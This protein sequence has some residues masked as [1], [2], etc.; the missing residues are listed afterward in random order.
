MSVRRRGP[1]VYQI[2]VDLG[3]DPVTGKRKRYY[4]TFKGKR[5]EALERER[6]ILMKVTDSPNTFEVPKDISVAEF[7]DDWLKEKA[8]AIRPSTLMSYEEQLK[9]Y[10]IPYIGKTALEDL[11]AQHLVRLYEHMQESGLSNRTIRYLH[12]IL[13]QALDRAVAWNVATH[14]VVKTVVPPRDEGT[15]FR[16]WDEREMERFLSEA[17]SSFYYEL[18]YV[19][20][21]TGMRFGELLGLKWRNVDFDARRI[22]VVEQYNDKTKTFDELKTKGSR[23]YIALDLGTINVLQERQKKQN[24]IR[25]KALYWEDLDLVFSTQ[26][27][28]PLMRRNVYRDFKALI[29]RTS[30]PEIRFHDLRHTHA[31]FLLTRGWHPKVVQER[32]GHTSIQI[33]LDT[34]SHVLPSLQ[35]KLVDATFEGTFYGVKMASKRPENKYTPGE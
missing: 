32:L 28:L 22:Y 34:Y 4:E 14:N 10:V 13:K 8:N 33:T 11:K 21:M 15:T 5:K 16:V 25:L 17:R 7:L 1:N 20:L 19:A 2:V 30:V 9:R 27:G 3:F 24:A 26:N 18:Y 6:E 23:R 35:D 31:T 12:T 29:R